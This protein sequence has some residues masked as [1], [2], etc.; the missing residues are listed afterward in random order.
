MAKIP[1]IIVTA[2]EIIEGQEDR[3]LGDFDIFPALLERSLNSRG[4]FQSVTSGK[5]GLLVNDLRDALPEDVLNIGW[6]GRLRLKDAL[7][8]IQ[9][10]IEEIGPDGIAAAQKVLGSVRQKRWALDQANSDLNKL[11]AATWTTDLNGIEYV[12]ALTYPNEGYVDAGSAE[13]DVLDAC[14]DAYIESGQPAPP[15]HDF[16]G[17]EYK[18]WGDKFLEWGRANSMPWAFATKGETLRRLT[19]DDFQEALTDCL[20]GGE[21]RARFN[22]EAVV[23]SILDAAAEDHH[24]DARDRVVDEAELCSTV[25]E[26]VKSGDDEALAESLKAWNE[27]QTIVS[28]TPDFS[29]AVPVFQGTSREQ[30]LA[31]SRMQVARCEEA[32]ASAVDSFPD[33]NAPDDNADPKVHGGP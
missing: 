31:W 10:K 26:W 32:L 4:Y 9:N 33:T 28:Y 21:G 8:K 30:A 11:L 17:P 14:Y 6:K 27:K 25:A 29:V 3:I 16:D 23:E 22:P 18:A 2:S 15:K 19:V 13:E 5:S 1:Q 7:T 12:Y 20:E 24:E